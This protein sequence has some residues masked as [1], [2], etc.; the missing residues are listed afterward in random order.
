MSAETLPGEVLARKA[1]V[2]VRQSTQT[3]VQTNLESQR[4]QYDLVALAKRHGFDTV[5]VIDDDLGRS[6]SGSVARPGFERLVAAVCTGGV[7]AGG[8]NTA[9]TG[10]TRRCCMVRH[11]ALK[12]AAWRSLMRHYLPLAGAPGALPGRMVSCAATSV[13]VSRSRSVQRLATADPRTLSSAVDV[14]AVTSRA[15]AHLHPAA[16]AVVEP[17]GRLLQRPQAAPGACQASCRAVYAALRLILPSSTA[18]LTSESRSGLSVTVSMGCQLR[19]CRAQRRGLAARA[20]VYSA[21][22]LDRMS[23]SSPA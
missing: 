15:D 7:G 11:A 13:L 14:A 1:I 10:L 9:D 18:A 2:Y 21:C 4:R 19:V 6:A 17:V 23:R 12:S 8:F 22:R 3:Q 5:E 16:V 20:S